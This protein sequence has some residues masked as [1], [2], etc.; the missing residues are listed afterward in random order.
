MKSGP[1][2]IGRLFFPTV[3]G[4]FFFFGLILTPQAALYPLQG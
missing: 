3:I 4:F 2:G 1:D